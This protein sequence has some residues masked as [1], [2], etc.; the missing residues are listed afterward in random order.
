MKGKARIYKA[1]AHIEPVLPSLLAIGGPS[2]C[3]KV[4][5][6]MRLQRFSF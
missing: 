1:G 2:I 5:R 4:D 6:R 3:I